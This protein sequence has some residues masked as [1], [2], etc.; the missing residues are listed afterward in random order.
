MLCILSR[1]SRRFECEIIF[2]K[3]YVLTFF[4]FASE[5]KFN[6][7]LIKSTTTT[8]IRKIVEIVTFLL[9]YFDHYTTFEIII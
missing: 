3:L 6:F 9:F 2:Q 4:F 5:I 8:K 7:N 1:I